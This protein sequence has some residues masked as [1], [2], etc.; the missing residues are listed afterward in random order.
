[1][2][3]RRKPII[4]ITNDDGYRAKGLRA[5]I[6][7]VQPFGQLIVIAP[8]E[9][10]SGMA[11]AITVKVPLRMEKIE[12]KEDFELYVCTGT[13][14]D[15][16]KLANN[17]IFKGMKPDLLI[18]GINHG[19]NSSSSVVYSGTMAAAI[20]GCL[21][22]IPAIGFSLLDFS[23][24]ADFTAAI[25]IVRKVVKNVLEN[26]IDKG[27]CLNVN[28]P[29]LPA[30]EIKGIKICRQN[31]GV[32]REEFDKRLDPNNREYYWL[33]GEFYNLEPHAED[34]DEWALHHG[35]ASIVPV[36]VDLTAYNSIDKLKS[37]NWENNG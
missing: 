19:A 5:L 11:H 7:A 16:V 17:Q 15:C 9:G 1:L 36:Q 13:P 14:V 30:S 34:T 4:L 32:W 6:E 2:E 18:S 29:R 10:Q 31:K 37:W 25:P 28:I 12:E 23:K 3:Y 35:Y 22:E 20:E 21:Y 24:N 33:T 8:S 27:T 26:G